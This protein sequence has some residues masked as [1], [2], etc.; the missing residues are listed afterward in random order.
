MLKDRKE[1]A[2][3]LGHKLEQYKGEKDILILGIP[4]GGVILAYYIAEELK[5][6]WDLIIPRK[7][8]APSHRELGIRQ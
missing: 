8:A 2:I 1:A 7:I 4:R 6:P 5:A 3:L